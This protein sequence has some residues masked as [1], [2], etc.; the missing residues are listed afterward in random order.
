VGARVFTLRHVGAG[1]LG[2]ESVHGG[3][4]AC[5]VIRVAA[6]EVGV[7]SIHLSEPSGKAVGGVRVHSSSGGALSELSGLGS[8]LSSL[9]VRAGVFTL[10]HVGAGVLG[11]ESVHGGH[12]ACLVI[13]V[14]ARE[15]GVGS[16]HLSEPSGKAVGG[17]RVHSSSGGALS[18]LSGLGSEVLTRNHLEFL[19]IMF[20]F[21]AGAVAFGPRLLSEGVGLGSLNLLGFL[22]FLGLL[23]IHLSEGGGSEVALHGRVEVLTLRHVRAGVLGAEVL[24]EGHV[25]SIVIRFA[26]FEGG[27]GVLIA[28][29]DL[30]RASSELAVK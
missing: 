23:S 6:R 20:V 11:A 17:V 9:L 21:A 30:V 4:V 25:A 16:I 1:V 29:F 24:H 26:F 5:L 3:H 2:A 8:L 12:V 19:V 13:R 28:E 7:G 14:A 15:V 18:E 10:R 27:A 22:G